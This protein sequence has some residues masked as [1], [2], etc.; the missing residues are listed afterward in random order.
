MLVSL[1]PWVCSP[2]D[3]IV[4]GTPTT[5]TLSPRSHAAQAV[6]GTSCSMKTTTITEGTRAAW[7][8]LEH[9]P[10]RGRRGVRGTR[11]CKAGIAR[12][13]SQKG[14]VCDVRVVRGLA[15]L[16]CLP[17]RFFVG[18]GTR[19]RMRLL[20][21][22]KTAPRTMLAQLVRAVAPVPGYKLHSLAGTP[23]LVQAQ[24]PRHGSV[25]QLRRL[26]VILQVISTATPLAAS[27]C[28]R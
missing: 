4:P 1:P 11:S 27:R 2:T 6:R 13:V 8:S 5:W 26:S 12:K 7:P 18:W 22:P 14:A 9:T 23:H 10:F 17:S 16:G 21:T 28:V 15:L 24:S 25:A 20:C 19:W 3:I